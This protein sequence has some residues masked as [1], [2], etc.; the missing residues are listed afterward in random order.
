MYSF[1]DASGF[2]GTLIGNDQV[3]LIIFVL[4]AVILLI[5]PP[6]RCLGRLVTGKPMVRDYSRV[7]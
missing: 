2:E 4:L 6:A 3:T 1:I 7:A 5:R